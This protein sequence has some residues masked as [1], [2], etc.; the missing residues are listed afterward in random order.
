[1]RRIGLDFDNTII[2]YDD[3]F[4]SAAKE[5]GLLSRDFSGTKQAVRDAIR[6]LPDGEIAWQKLQGF[7]YGKGIGGAKAFD[8]FAS[9]MKRAQASGDELIIVSHKTEYGHFDPERVNL[10]QAALDWMRGQ[11]FF[12][13]DGF[14]I[15]IENIYFE[16]TRA[17]KLRRIAATN[18]ELF[19]D[20]LEEVLSDPDFPKTV[21]RI[22]FSDR[23]VAAEA[24]PYKVCAGWP[25]VEEVIFA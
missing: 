6:A 9:F 19:V 5:R 20:D 3:V 7:V 18:C 15:A 21:D 16:S 17:E 23:P 10:R 4:L 14:G 24:A 1:M 22:L 13:A 12:G 2:C 11:R 25:A 8:G